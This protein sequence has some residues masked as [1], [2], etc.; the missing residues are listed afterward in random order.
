MDFEV[1]V[2][3]ANSDTEG[4][5]FKVTWIYPSVA[6]KLWLMCSISFSVQLVKISAFS[7]RTWSMSPSI[8]NGVSPY[9]FSLCDAVGKPGLFWQVFYPFTSTCSVRFSLFLWPRSALRARRRY[10]PSGH[11]ANLVTSPV[12][13]TCRCSHF[14]QKSVTS[15]EMRSTQRAHARSADFGHEN[16]EKRSVLPLQNIA[17]R[18]S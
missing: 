10:L 2:E 4:L 13:F 17:L 12:F 18:T 6:F 5:K 3:I 7:Y 11:L 1:L 9:F 15:P 14:T 16:S 8:V